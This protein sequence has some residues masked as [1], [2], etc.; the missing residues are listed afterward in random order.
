LNEKGIVL[1]ADHFGVAPGVRT[2]V[3]PVGSPPPEGNSLSLFNPP[4]FVFAF[5]SSIM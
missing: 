4:G 1:F 5:E 2:E 3:H